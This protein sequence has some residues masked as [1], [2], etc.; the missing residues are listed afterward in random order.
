M[1]ILGNV[2]KERN[3]QDV[4]TASNSDDKPE[5]RRPGQD[6]RKKKPNAGKATLSP[7]KRTKDSPTATPESLAKK[8]RSQLG[9]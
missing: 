2:P 5:Q 1:A 9:L 8:G 4:S 6:G 3:E 7:S